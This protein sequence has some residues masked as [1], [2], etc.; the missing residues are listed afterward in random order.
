VTTL[1]NTS[2]SFLEIYKICVRV[3]SKVTRETIIFLGVIDLLNR[4]EKEDEGK[5]S[6][7]RD[8]WYTGRVHSIPKQKYKQ[9]SGIAVWG[10]GW[11]SVKKDRK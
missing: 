3:D 8:E 10:E 11:N 6:R 2:D 9:R 1:D 4:S 5:R 7:G